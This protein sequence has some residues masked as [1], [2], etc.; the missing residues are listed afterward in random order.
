MKKIDL[1]IHTISTIS[2]AGF[3]F[4]LE[5]FKRYVEE[6]SLDAVAVTNHDVFDVDQFREIQGALNTVV[7]PGIEINVMKGHVLI[8]GSDSQ[9]DDFEAKAKIV[10]QKIT[11]IG[12]FLSVD[13]LISIYGDLDQYLVI[14]HYDKSPPIRGEALE[15]LRPYICAGEVDS[16]KKFVRSI[17]DDTKPTP[18]LFSDFR[19][20]ADLPRLPTRQTYI[21]CGEVTLG[22]LK[23]CLRDKAKVSLTES[24][25]NNLWQ[26][27]EGGQK[28]STGLNVLI[29]ARSSG[30]THTLDEVS[31][32]VE[33]TKYI[34]QFSLVQQSEADYEREFTSEVERR[35]SVF[36]DD[37]L[38]GL[39]RVLDDVMNV[40]LEAREREL[41]QYVETLLK[42]AEETDRQDAF[43]KSKL[44]DEVK[45]PLGN[46]K[47]LTSL[48]DSVKQIIENIEFRKVIE[49]HIELVALKSLVVEL[50]ELYRDRNFNNQ[51]MKAVNDLIDEI[52]QGLLLRT[53]ATQVKDI[54]IY[55]CCIDK[56]RVER[57]VEIVNALKQETVIFEESLQ[58]FKIEAI[59]APYAGAGEMKSASGTRAAFSGAFLQYSDPYKYLRCLLSNENLARADLYKLF[60]KIS[61]RILNEDGFEVS[62]GERSEF[63]L[64]QEISDAQNYDMLLIDEPESSFDNLFLKS[65]VNKIL[66]SISETMPV[67]VV[68]HNSTVGASVGADYLLYTKKEIE[69]GRV[70]YR[71]YSGYPTDKILSSVD[72]RTIK[73]HEIM[74]NSLEAGATAYESRRKG[75]EAIKD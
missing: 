8:I 59:K 30:K 22:A 14:P 74:M 39:K 47:T 26:V 46:N 51:K 34:K 42:S 49:K 24:D 16:A 18:V 48:I 67:V 31:A 27:L 3:T 2:D 19:M 64:L 17:K 55:E 52:K 44:F 28:M 70:L 12:D 37:Y 38:A 65:D 41:D 20:K 5:T 25:G 63:R 40:D 15:Q 11:K 53:S 35:R 6:A 36:V 29:G 75:Y 58:G 73:S 9:L 56:K 66:K 68:T 43:S 21:D 62:G 13:E 69:G 71:L 1:H 45:F 32:T 7:F 50:I 23:A 60:T 61:Y 54:D 72:G 4:S 57:F 33:H 10:S